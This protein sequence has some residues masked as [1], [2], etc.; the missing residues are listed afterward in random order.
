MKQCALD[1]QLVDRIGI[2]RM[3]WTTGAERPLQ[4]EKSHITSPG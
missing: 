2:V 4:M 1:N 3:L